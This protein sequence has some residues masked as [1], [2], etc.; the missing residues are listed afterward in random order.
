MTAMSMFM[1]L[2][3]EGQVAH[4]HVVASVALLQ[5]LALDGVL[6]TAVATLVRSVAVAG[7]TIKVACR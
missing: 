5:V 7:M 2:V 1:L 4:A 3:H 6:C